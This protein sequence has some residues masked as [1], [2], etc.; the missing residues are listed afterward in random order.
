M[1]FG[2]WDTKHR[3]ATQQQRKSTISDATD[4]ETGEDDSESLARCELKWSRGNKHFLTGTIRYRQVFIRARVCFLAGEG[5]DATTT[6]QQSG[7]IA[8]HSEWWRARV[9]VAAL[10]ASV[11]FAPT[12]QVRA[13][14]N[15]P[16]TVV[17]VD[18]VVQVGEPLSHRIVVQNNTTL[19][20]TLSLVTTK[21]LWKQ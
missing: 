17:D 16:V 13:R 5:V 12:A 6:T 10:T 1:I 21:L 8:W 20:Q 11:H 9:A 15:S 19:Q 3:L 18:N 2:L 14:L 7:G 4:D